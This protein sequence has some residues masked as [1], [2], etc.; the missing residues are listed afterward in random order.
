MKIEPP[1]ESGYAVLDHLVEK[2]KATHGFREITLSLTNTTPPIQTVRGD[3]P[4][5]VTIPQHMRNGTFVAVAKFRRNSCYTADL[6]GQLTVAMTQDQVNACRSAIDEIVVSNPLAETLDANVEKDMSF[7]FA[8]PIP[9]EA[10][11]PNNFADRALFHN[12]SAHK[13][14]FVKIV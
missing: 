2:D 3:A 14:A 4:Q 5:L 6:S 7:T 10:A 11:T 12:G 1:R 8:N 13:T 9:I